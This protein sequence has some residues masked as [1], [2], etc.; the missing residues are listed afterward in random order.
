MTDDLIFKGHA[1]CTWVRANNG[2]I[3]ATFEPEPNHPSVEV[4]ETN[5]HRDHG[6]PQR[7]KLYLFD[8]QPAFPHDAERS[9]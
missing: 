8:I 5:L 3:Q 7:G 1:R 2:I 4:I 9:G 6:I